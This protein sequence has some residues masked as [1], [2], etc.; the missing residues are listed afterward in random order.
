M[1][2][3]DGVIA[4][5]MEQHAEA[6]R[7]VLGP[8]GVQVE[9]GQ[10]FL[11]EGARSESIIRDFLAGAGV[12]VTPS[13]IEVLA[14]QKQ[15]AFRALGMP[16]LYPGAAKMVD[17]VQATRPTAVVTGTRLQNLEA[18][19][20]D[21]L[22]KFGA[23][24]SQESYTHDKPHPEPYAR[25]AEALGID[26]SRCVA[27]ENA[28]RGVQSARAAGYGRVIG[29]ATTLQPELLHAAGA[30]AVYLDHDSLTAALLDFDVANK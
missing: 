3:F 25:A 12:S 9:D 24:M 23:V 29:I 1:F 13:Q 14:N 15:D 2:D 27:V 7:R 17:A 18:M 10:V 6:Y 11:V 22:P 19:I 5:S 16:H 21:L 20:P 30:D 28:I 26:P 4:K 8:L